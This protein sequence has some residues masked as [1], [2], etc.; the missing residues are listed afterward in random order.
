L[1]LILPHL[2]VFMRHSKAVDAD[3]FDGP[4][5]QRPLTRSG[6]DLATEVARAFLRQYRPTIVIASDFVRAV[7][8]AR[9]VIEQIPQKQRP[10]LTLTPALRPE[11][12]FD[13]W[14]DYY[15]ANLTQVKPTDTVMLV[16]HEPSL[17]CIFGRHLGER[18]SAWSFK[19]AGIAMIQP[20]SWESGT[21]VDWTREAHP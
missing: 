10:A 1:N 8:T 12:N 7:E 13:D 17:A 11:A 19:K 20:R 4:D 21:I 14:T 15:G 6:K 3:E 2:L 18:H 5:G 9:I 16:G